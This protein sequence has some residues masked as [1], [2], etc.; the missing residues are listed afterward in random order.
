MKVIIPMTGKS[1][2]FKNAGIDLPKQFL[3]IE[4]KMIAQH[5]LDMFPGESDI[6]F[7]GKESLKK[8]N[9]DGIKRKQVG[10]EIHCD[11]LEGPNTKF[12]PIKKNEN[13]RLV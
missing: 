4:S 11:P 13:N 2:R 10:L 9:K 6:N 5:I 1:K 12:W 3:E 8:I 7:I